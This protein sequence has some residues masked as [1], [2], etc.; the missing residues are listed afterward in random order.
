MFVYS[1]FLFIE[2]ARLFEEMSQ[3]SIS[4]AS[5]YTLDVHGLTEIR[6]E[7]DISDKFQRQVQANAHVKR[8]VHLPSI[9]K[10]PKLASSISQPLISTNKLKSSNPWRVSGDQIERKQD[11][12]SDLLAV[13]SMR[14]ELKGFVNDC[15]NSLHRRPWLRVDKR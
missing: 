4:N 6:R 11:E 9:A 8:Q 12:L 7:Q 10:G 14:Q 1:L 2:K 5:T 15:A 13:R 3:A